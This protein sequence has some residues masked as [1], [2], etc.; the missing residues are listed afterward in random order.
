MRL[1]GSWQWY[2]AASARQEAIRR[3][4]NE[5][6]AREAEEIARREADDQR[7]LAQNLSA[8]LTLDQGLRFREEGQVATGLL[9]MVPC[10]DSSVAIIGW[11]SANWRGKCLIT[12]VNKERKD[13]EQRLEQTTAQWPR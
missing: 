6:E 8:G 10:R 9:W 3:A 7:R 13:R 4:E 12:L 5:K 11:R 2:E 1:L